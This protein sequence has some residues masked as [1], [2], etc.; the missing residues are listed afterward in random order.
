MYGSCYSFTYLVTAHWHVLMMI[1]KFVCFLSRVLFFISIP[2]FCMRLVA[3]FDNGMLMV[4]EFIFVCFKVNRHFYVIRCRKT[5]CTG[6]K[7]S[8][9]IILSLTSSLHN[10]VD[11]LYVTTYAREIRV[12]K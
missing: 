8:L 12:F 10:R 7:L 4:E 5:N 9:L 3:S 6:Q 2:L 1:L 11:F